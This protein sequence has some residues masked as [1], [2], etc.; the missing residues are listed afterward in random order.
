[1]QLHG[2]RER[3]RGRRGTRGALREKVPERTSMQRSYFVERSRFLASTTVRLAA[4]EGVWVHRQPSRGATATQLTT[5]RSLPCYST[6]LSSRCG[7]CDRTSRTE[8]RAS[9]AWLLVLLAV[10][11]AAYPCPP[12]RSTRTPACRFRRGHLPTGAASTPCFNHVPPPPAPSVSAPP[13][14]PG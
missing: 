3:W 7:R 11:C 13:R 9:R 6:A 10:L 2:S 8:E 5:A 4:P 12:S 14:L 1:M